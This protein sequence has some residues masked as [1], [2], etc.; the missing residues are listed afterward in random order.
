MKKIILELINQLIYNTICQSQIAANFEWLVNFGISGISL[1]GESSIWSLCL[2]SITEGFGL[3]KPDEFPF[4]ITLIYWKV[5]CEEVDSTSC[6]LP[7]SSLTKMLI[8]WQIMYFNK[9]WSY[10]H[11]VHPSFYF[12]FSFSF[13]FLFIY[14]FLLVN[15]ISLSF[16]H[17]ILFHLSTFL[18]SFRFWS[19]NYSSV[20]SEIRQHCTNI[21]WKHLQEWYITRVWLL[22]I[23]IT[24][25]W[26]RYGW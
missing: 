1:F 19:I 10:F 5:C 25:I 18:I 23:F 20:T 7:A 11:I 8:F 15:S 22:P 6:R 4:W 12:F 13:S 14:I 21:F 2:L 9:S 24:V 3:D 16:E 26:G 17:W